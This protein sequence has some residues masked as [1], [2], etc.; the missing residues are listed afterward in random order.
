MPFCRC[1]RRRRNAEG[2]SSVL[3][4]AALQYRN[5]RNGFHTSN[6]ISSTFIRVPTLIT[7]P[8]MIFFSKCSLIS[9]GLVTSQEIL[10]LLGTLTLKNPNGNPTPN[11][12]TVISA[13]ATNQ[14]LFNIPIATS[15]G[16]PRDLFDD[17][18]I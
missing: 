1:R 13:T 10:N 5:A 16:K 14:K 17:Q 11:N 9:L 6:G 3:I 18:K 2:F 8:M 4:H 15:N 7:H 12:N